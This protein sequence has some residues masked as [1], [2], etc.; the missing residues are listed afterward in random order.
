MHFRN[1]LY[2]IQQT[3]SLSE[4]VQT[5]EV[6]KFPEKTAT[7]TYKLSITSHRI[8]KIAELYIERSRK[9]GIPL[10]RKLSASLYVIKHVVHIDRY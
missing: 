9:G 10:N 1:A 4:Q 6:C 8:W 2:S 3:H 5:M 7:T